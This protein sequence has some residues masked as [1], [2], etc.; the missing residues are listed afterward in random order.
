M[1]DTLS[2]SLKK[3]KSDKTRHLRTAAIMLILSLIVTTNVFWSLRQTGIALAG[4]AACGIEEHRHTEECIAKT[5]VCPLSEDGHIH[6]DDCYAAQLTDVHTEAVL[7][8]DLTD[9]PHEHTD[10][11][12]ETRHVDG[13]DET[14]LSCDSTEEAHTHDDSC[15]TVTHMDGYDESVL[16]CGLTVQPHVH[17]DD[18]YTVQTVEA[19]EQP[20]LICDLSEEPHTHTDDCWEIT[21]ICGKEEHTHSIEC[22][23]DENADVETP[24]DWQEMFDGYSTGDLPKDLVNIAKSQIGYTESERNFQ[25]DDDGNRHGYTR[26]GAWYGAPYSDWSAMFVSFC[27]NYAGSDPSETP[28]NIGANAMAS[29]WAELGK[30]AAAREYTP[31]SG[32]LVFFSDHTVGIVTEI[33]G[34][35]IHV[36]MGDTDD[37]VAALELLMTDPSITGWG[38]TDGSDPKPDAEDAA[39][40]EQEEADPPQGT[41]LT[42]TQ[43]QLLD[44][45]NGPAVYIF[46]SPTWSLNADSISTFGLDRAAGTDI[47]DYAEAHNGTFTLTLLNTNDTSLPT[48]D[49]GNYIVTAEQDYKLSLGIHLPNGIHPGTYTYQ[50]P[51]GLNIV[52]GSGSFIIDD[53]GEKVN[54]GTWTIDDGGLITFVMNENTNNYTDVTISATMG[55]TFDETEGGMDFDD[56]VSVTVKPPESE[57]DDRKLRKNGQG[58]KTDA[59]GNVVDANGNPIDHVGSNS[60]VS[61][62]EGFERIRWNVTIWGENL[63][64]VTGKGISDTIITGDTLHYTGKDMELGIYFNYE[65]PDGKTHNW[66][67]SQDDPALTWNESSWTYTIP[68]TVHCRRHDDDITLSDEGKYTIIY[69]STVNRDDLGEGDHG[70]RNQFTIDGNTVEG[71]TIEYITVDHSGIIKTGEFDASTGKFNWS[72][73][74]TL[75]G[76]DGKSHKWKITDGSRLVLGNNSE[77]TYMDT[78]KYYDKITNFTVTYDGQTY[79]VYPLEEAP[80]DA[81]F[82]YYIT[83][84][85]DGSCIDFILGKKCTCTKGT[86]MEWSDSKGCMNYGPFPSRPYE[87]GYCRCWDIPGEAVVQI[88]YTRDGQDLI[89][90]YGG[91]NY[92]YRNTVTLIKSTKDTDGSTLNTNIDKVSDTVPIPGVFKKGLTESASQENGYIATYMITVNESFLDLSGQKPLTIQDK[93]SDTLVYVPGTMTITEKAEN[94][95]SRALTVNEDYTITYDTASHSITLNILEPGAYQY[96]LVYKTQIVIPSGSTTVDYENSA[97]ITLFGQ[98]FTKEDQKYT[99]SDIN[100]AAKR[101][102]VQIIKTEGDSGTNAPLP[103]AEFGLFASNG[104]LVVSG[105]TDE[106]GTLSFQTSLDAGII[107]R[108]HTA[109]YIQEIQAPEGYATDK[110]KHWFCFCD[111]K[112]T[113]CDTCTS[114]VTEENGFRIPYEE[115]GTVHAVNYTAHYHLPATGG[116]GISHFILWGSVLI[117]TPLVYGYILRRKRERRGDQ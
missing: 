78:D 53:K 32:D 66:I 71:S 1:R 77:L 15:Y 91:R 70:F 97:T 93:M 85:S 114:I 75:D 83:T 49:D 29:A 27:L 17:T 12:Y 26:Y 41:F 90:E 22:Y 95:T 65:D 72:I 30:Y 52:D 79:K 5:L 100:I 3:L 34:Y 102:A 69:Y 44:I 116:A 87:S 81:E 58:V 47:R 8:C 37:A 86:C 108:E 109:Y 84:A 42:V 74:A 55:V 57:S 61:L 40:D 60:Y 96:T 113:S 38:L 35:T 59:D 45:S 101:Y 36:V 23:S 92:S 111:N 46:A 80:E 20:L 11:C 107:L 115:T 16:V 110:T 25:I 67:V 105:K 39:A 62:D 103:G 21:Y 99:L 7:T 98:Q 63:N 56:L 106:T 50:L 89:D 24:L 28:F 112:E 13:Y 43:E 48:D 88:N 10:A 31:Q 104:E 68:D 76:S 117:I 54:L 6:T 51:K 94:G 18:C 64:G 82:V 33:Y 73:T 2:E 4:D 9:E 14:I 19:Y